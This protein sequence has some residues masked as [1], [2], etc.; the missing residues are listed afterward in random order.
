MAHA[1]PKESRLFR[2]CTKTFEGVEEKMPILFATL[3]VDTWS[4]GIGMKREARC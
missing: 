4:D 1:A 3:Q 2:G